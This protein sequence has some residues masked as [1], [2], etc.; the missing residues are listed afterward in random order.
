MINNKEELGIYIHIPFCQ[1]KCNYCDFLSMPL[2][3]SGVKAAYVK[4]LAEE[5]AGFEEAE[6]FTV[7]TIYL[8]GGT[9]SLLSAAELETLVRSLENRFSWHPG[10]E[11][12]MECNPGTV[13]AE[14]LAGYL[15][16]G[17]NRL[18]FGLQ[19]TENEELRL[20]GRIHTWEKFNESYSLARE[21]GCANINIDLMSGL[22]GQSLESWSRTLERTA[23]LEPEHI[24][25]YSLMI[26]EGTPFYERYAEDLQRR[27]KGEAC[28]L[29]PSEDTERQMYAH[30]AEYLAGRGYSQYEISNY[31][32]PGHACLHN[33]SYWEGISYAG[34]GLGASSLIRR[35]RYRNR[36]DLNAYL[37]GDFSKKELFVLTKDNQIEEFMFLGLRK[38]RGVSRREFYRRFGVPM[39]AVYKKEL[40]ELL[41]LGLLAEEGDYIRLTRKGID[42]SNGVLAKFLL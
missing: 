11:F 5:I 18:S 35:I 14:S 30:T 23:G 24:S 19:S 17:V 2:A 12:T 16:L 21:A 38:T 13:T 1:K 9:P 7:R 20:L 42:V 25:A 28:C 4:R 26:E 39:D 34:F 29:L 32:K 15:S 36:R 3:D 27:E 22:P 10:I 37:N 8:G 40:A 33:S 41:Q 6:D 31:A